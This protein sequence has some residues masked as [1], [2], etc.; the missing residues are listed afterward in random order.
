MNLWCCEAYGPELDAADPDNA[1]HCFF[2][3]AGA[4]RSAEECAGRMQVE[5]LRLWRLLSKMATDGDPVG[6]AMLAEA[7]GPDDLLNY[8]H[9]P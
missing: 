7:T 2:E 4:C 1:P 5:R 6:L 8:R 3:L 9:R